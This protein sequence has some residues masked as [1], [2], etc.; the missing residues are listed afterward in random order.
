MAGDKQIPDVDASAGPG[1]TGSKPKNVADATDDGSSNTDDPIASARAER[2]AAKEKRRAAEERADALEAEL[3][4]L[5]QRTEGLEAIEAEHE[6]LRAAEQARHREHTTRDVAA[7]L[8]PHFGDVI[9]RGVLLA[10]AEQGKVDLE[11]A[12]AAAVALEYLRD[13]HPGMLRQGGDSG[14]D[15]VTRGATIRW[16]SSAI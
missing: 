12:D 8:A 7:G 15:L 16:R 6:Q 14:P 10:L 3:A 5:K 13:A 1:D 4:E 11:A 2:D 9:A